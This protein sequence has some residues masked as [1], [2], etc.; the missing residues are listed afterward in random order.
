MH[1]IS[2]LISSKHSDI[3]VSILKVSIKFADNKCSDIN[4]VCGYQVC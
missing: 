3:K 4:S 1:I 2:V